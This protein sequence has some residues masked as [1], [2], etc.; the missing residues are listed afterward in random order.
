MQ[1]TLPLRGKLEKSSVGWCHYA[2]GGRY[3][4]ERGLPLDE[5]EGWAGESFREAEKA[6]TKRGSGENMAA[7]VKIPLYA[8]YRL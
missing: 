3:R 4:I 7:K 2:G 1:Q 5:K 6:R 8:Y